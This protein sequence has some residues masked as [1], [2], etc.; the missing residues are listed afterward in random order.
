[1]ARIETDCVPRRGRDWEGKSGLC[2]FGFESQSSNGR[3]S[4]L[5]VAWAALGRKCGTSFSLRISD[6]FSIFFIDLP[7]INEFYKLI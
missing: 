7:L 2:L 5:I 6:I 1:V 3:K 4:D